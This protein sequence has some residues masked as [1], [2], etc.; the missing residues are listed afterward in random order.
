MLFPLAG[1]GLAILA[2]FLAQGTT[3]VGG[4]DVNALVAEADPIRGQQSGR[5]CLA[6]HT[7]ERDAK[8]GIGPNLWGIYGRS[9]AAAENFEYS[10]ALRNLDGEWTPENLNSYLSGPANF[11][12]GTK[13][14]F[15]GIANPRDRSD[16]IAWIET[17][18]DDPESIPKSGSASDSARIPDP[19]GQ[20]WP[21]G[22]GRELAGYTCNTCHSLAIVK[23]QGLSRRGWEET[24]DWMIEEQGLSELAQGDRKHIVDFLAKHFGI[25]IQ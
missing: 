12:P 17:L 16:V 3:L 25:D 5:Q 23:Q 24:I 21:Q 14:T 20:D 19:F 15:P 11:A 4:S 2:L 1:P 22:E 6:C 7:A 18:R 10:P 13:M 9:I 8:A